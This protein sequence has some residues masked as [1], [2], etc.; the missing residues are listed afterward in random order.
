M[1]RP[2]AYRP[3][4]LCRACVIRW[5]VIIVVAVLCIVRQCHC[6]AVRALASC[7]TMAAL[8]A[9]S[10]GVLS[11]CVRVMRRRVVHRC[12]CC[13]APCVIVWWWPRHR[14]RV[15]VALATHVLLLL[16]SLCRALAWHRRRA[17]C[18][19]VMV[20][21]VAAWWQWPRHCVVVATSSTSCHRG[22]GHA[23]LV[24]V[25]IA[26]AVWW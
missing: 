23:R 14:C 19:N 3:L 6:D 20:V 8:C 9:S 26:I 15:V 11:S 21:V 2:L 1:R 4:S 7:I 13:H 12:R 10:V 22:T 24:V 25:V 16:L 17:L 18:V 5:H